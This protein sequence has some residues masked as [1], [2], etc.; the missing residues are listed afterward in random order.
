MKDTVIPMHYRTLGKSESSENLLSNLNKYYNWYTQYVGK[1]IIQKKKQFEQVCSSCLNSKFRKWE[2]YGS[3][4]ALVANSE[5]ATCLTRKGHRATV[6][7]WDID[8]FML[9]WI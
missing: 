3:T 7:F 6:E 9:F 8:E 4:L 2:R 5:Y 1:K